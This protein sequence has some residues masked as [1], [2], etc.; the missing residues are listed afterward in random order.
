MPSR[1]PSPKQGSILGVELPDPKW[2]VPVKEPVPVGA[3]AGSLVEIPQAHAQLLLPSVA[4]RVA[5]L[6]IDSPPRVVWSHDGSELLVHTDKVALACTAGLITVAVVAQCD[7]VN[8]A[9]TLTVPFAVGTKAAP[10]GLV[11]HTFDRLAGPAIITERW[12]PS[13]I[14][15]AW[16]LVVELCSSLCAE[17]GSD[18][19]H[20]ALIPG[21]IGA[22]PRLL[23]VQPIA[24][25]NVNLKAAR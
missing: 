20:R 2:F 18:V 25:H 1:R 6:P 22:A 17:L 15:F 4:R 8:G 7:Q 23:L 14:A 3:L 5:D 16:E 21:S 13:V 24:R 12:S 19:R 10:S 9:V 11:M